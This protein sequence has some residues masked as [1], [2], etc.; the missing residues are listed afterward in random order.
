MGPKEGIE[1]KLP[2]FFVYNCE[3]HNLFSARIRNLGLTPWL[4]HASLLKKCDVKPSLSGIMEE[5][6]GVNF[7]QAV[8]RHTPG[9]VFYV[10][11]GYIRGFPYNED[12]K[13]DHAP[14]G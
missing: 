12:S 10:P 4:W 5:R 3:D 13:P 6:R 7:W 11:L 8:S 1:N 9:A 2:G 14:L